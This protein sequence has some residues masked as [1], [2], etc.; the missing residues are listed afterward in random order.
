L[1]Q[2]FLIVVQLDRQ[3][4]QPPPSRR[5]AGNATAF[6]EAHAADE[7]AAEADLAAYYARELNLA[8]PAGAARAAIGQVVD[9]A[10]A[11]C[12]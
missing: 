2:R 7:S 11:G 4:S 8:D 12:S 3:G 1:Y 10:F 5:V 9:K 6:T